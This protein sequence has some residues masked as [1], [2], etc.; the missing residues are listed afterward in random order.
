MFNRVLGMIFILGGILGEVA[1]FFYQG[2]FHNMGH[3]YFIVSALFV[4]MM[5]AGLI[6][7]VSEVE[8]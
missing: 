1:T 3:F 5:A 4:V 7:F 2:T 6:M 8:E